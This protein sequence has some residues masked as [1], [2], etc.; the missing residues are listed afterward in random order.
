MP[1]NVYNNIQEPS[2]SHESSLTFLAKCL[3][4]DYLEKMEATSLA[5]KMVEAIF[6]LILL[7]S[8]FCYNE[9]PLE[10]GDV[11]ECFDY[12]KLE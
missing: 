2:A 8:R 12:K 3:S 10:S 9:N 11:S 7:H 1:V 4:N 5:S 6:G